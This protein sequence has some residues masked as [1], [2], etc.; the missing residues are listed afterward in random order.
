[1]RTDYTVDRALLS[2]ELPIEREIQFQYV[3]SWLAQHAKI[4]PFGLL[5]HHRAQH[6]YCSIV[7]FWILIAAAFYLTATKFRFDRKPSRS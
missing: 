4:A 2:R 5:Q 1:M 6:G 7:M 3:H